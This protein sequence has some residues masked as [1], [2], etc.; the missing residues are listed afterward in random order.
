M[1]EKAH[2]VAAWGDSALEK[3]TNSWFDSF[4]IKI[5]VENFMEFDI[6][7]LNLSVGEHAQKIW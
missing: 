6:W 4:S 3:L 1:N 5:T 2:H 7:I